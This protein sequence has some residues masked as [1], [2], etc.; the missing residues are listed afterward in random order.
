MEQPAPKELK[1]IFASVF[2]DTKYC[3]K[4]DI[5]RPH[6]GPHHD[7]SAIDIYLSA[8]DPDEKELA[9][10]IVQLLIQEKLLVKWGA[11][12]W[13]RLTWDGRGG[14]LPYEQA[15]TMPHREHIHVEWGEKGRLTLEFPGLEEK[16]K[17]VFIAHKY[18]L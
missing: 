14:P 6:H 4:M 11:V 16:L 17:E 5:F 10:A 9:D 13:N 8:D 1:R 3:Q 2:Q 18:G 12:I 7:G 15:K